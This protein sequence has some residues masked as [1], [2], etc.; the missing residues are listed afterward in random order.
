MNDPN[1]RAPGL[2][3]RY[4]EE[5]LVRRYAKGTITSY[6]SWVRRYLRFHHLRDPLAHCYSSIAPCF[7]VMSAAWR[8]SCGAI[9]LNDCPL[10]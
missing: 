8:A 1:T 2:P 7:V 3:E 10:F 4:R 9:D 6:G 5:M